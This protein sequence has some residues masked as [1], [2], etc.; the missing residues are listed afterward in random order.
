MSNMTNTADIRAYILGAHGAFT[1]ESHKTGQH[2]TYRVSSVNDRFFI[3]VM[4]GGADDYEYLGMIVDHDNPTMRVIPTRASRFN[5]VSPTMAAVNWF[6]RHIAVRPEI[7]ESIVSFY[8]NGRCA[9]CGRELTD[10]ESIERGMGPVCI[11]RGAV[12]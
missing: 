5:A 11:A 10:P 1:I 12:H 9:R 7:D 3:H 6:M 8:H 2:Y 4:T